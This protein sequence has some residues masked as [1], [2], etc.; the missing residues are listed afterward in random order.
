MRKAVALLLALAL[1]PYA[2]WCESIEVHYF[3]AKFLPVP[4]AIVWAKFQ[5]NDYH[6]LD[7]WISARTNLSGIAR[8]VACDYVPST[9]ENRTY[10]IGVTSPFGDS[11]VRKTHVGENPIGA[12]GA[13][14]EDFFLTYA[15][16]DIRV[17]ARHVHGE[18]L[19]GV[20]LSM[21]R[22]YAAERITDSKGLALF[23]LK[24]GLPFTIIG[25]YHDVPANVSGRVEGD[26]LIE[27][28]FRVFN[29]TLDVLVL[30]VE[31]A[32]IK[33]ARLELSYHNTS[34]SALSDEAGSA[35]FSGITSDN[36]TLTASYRGVTAS[37]SILLSATRSAV[38]LTLDR[39]PLRANVTSIKPVTNSVC[40]QLLV[41]AEAFDPRSNAS[42]LN[43]SFHYLVDNNLFT[44][45]LS[46]AGNNTFNGSIN[47][48]ALSLPANITYYVV[49]ASPWDTG[50]SAPGTLLVAAST[51]P[52]V[53]IEDVSTSGPIE[54][55]VE[56][57]F[58]GYITRNAMNLLLGAIILIS[59]ITLI[60]LFIITLFG[61][62]KKQEEELLPPPPPPKPLSRSG[63]EAPEE[64]QKPA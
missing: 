29:N 51:Q 22:P 62:G 40:L 20:R 56:I 30:D 47:C 55:V 26:A 25:H 24:P 54:E 37:K 59:V 2:E 44:Q 42:E 46:H 7:G 53:Y 17:R 43:V 32:P 39:N 27:L 4:D 8:L 45:N 14:R 48:S 9:S 6:A 57:A 41:T 19:A 33:G 11:E 60:V 3:D 58:I 50:Q 35:R 1:A 34:Q 63:M 49:A 31:G 52:P 38:N 12:G 16:S 64:G 23:R 61:K 36:V 10:F 21:E 5:K 15:L 18:P 13:H 28:V